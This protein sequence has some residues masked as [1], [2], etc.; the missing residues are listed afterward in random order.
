MIYKVEVLDFDGKVRENPDFPTAIVRNRGVQTVNEHTGEDVEFMIVDPVFNNSV[1][2]NLYGRV[3]TLLEATIEPTRIKAVK[4][5]FS[6]ELQSWSND[7]H[8]SAT[9]LAQGGNSDR[10]IYTRGR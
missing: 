10:N 8:D 5:V 4:D 3:M 9:Q 6:K 1:Y 2:N 7:V